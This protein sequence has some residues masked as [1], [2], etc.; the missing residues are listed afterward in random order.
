MRIGLPKEIKVDEGRVGL[1]PGGVR[2]LVADGHEVRVQTSAGMSAGY[3][4]SEYDEAGGTIVP[5]AEEAWAADLVVKVK[6]PLPEEYRFFRAD[7][8]LFTYLH[9]AANRALT[10]ALLRSN[11]TAVGY[12]T[13]QE[14]DGTLPLLI[15]MSEVAGRMAAQVGARCLEKPH[16]GRG[17]LLGGVPGVLPGRVVIIGGGVVGLN[18]ARIAMGFG[19]EVVVLDINAQRL[20][21]LDALFLGKLR[22][23]A[24][25]EENIASAVKSSDFVIGAV[26]IAGERAPH[27]VPEDLVKTMRPGSVLVD[28]AIDQG[29]CIATMDHVT[30]HSQPTYERFN[31][32]HYAVGNMPGAVPRTSTLALTHVTLPYVRMIAESGYTEAARNN[33]ALQRGANVIKGQVVHPAVAKAH[34]LAVR[35]IDDIFRDAAPA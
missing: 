17:I 35:S 34:Q 31:V 11:M 16:G 14:S 27:L 30:T 32:V 26:L 12:E 23:L 25:T 22:T 8:T 33:L 19:A 6:D 10:S 21:E 9:L 20:R 5:T 1:T 29:G 18:A 2:R 24:S 7:L 28:V 15:P 3:S 4:D 13:V